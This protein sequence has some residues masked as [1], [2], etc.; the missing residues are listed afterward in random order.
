MASRLVTT[1]TRSEDDILTVFFLSQTYK[2]WRG[3]EVLKY[4]VGRKIL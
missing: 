1:S 2:Y 3:E 4:R